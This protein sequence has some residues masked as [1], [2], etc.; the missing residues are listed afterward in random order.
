MQIYILVVI[1]IITSS[2]GVATDTRFQEFD[3]RPACEA[4]RDGIVAGVNRIKG[5]VGRDVYAACYAKG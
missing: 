3:N 5:T 4:A 1:T 2:T